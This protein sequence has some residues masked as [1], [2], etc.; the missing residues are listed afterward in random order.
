VWRARALADAEG[1]FV[2]PAP[3]STRPAAA[4]RT[5]AVGPYRVAGAGA[6]VRVAVSETA[7]ASGAAVEVPPFTE[8]EGRAAIALP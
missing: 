2:L 4:G 6:E 5:G 3:Y 1:R 7:V 8:G